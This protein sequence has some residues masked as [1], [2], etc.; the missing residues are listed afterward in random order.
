MGIPSFFKTSKPKQYAYKPRYYDPVKEGLEERINQIKEEMG[1]DTPNA[2]GEGYTRKI[3]RGQMRGY[4]RR[5]EKTRRQSNI[6]LVIII[7]FLI[8]LA[9]FLFF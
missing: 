7:A 8:F 4:L 5:N 1:I 3:Q 2:T 9:Y 6:R